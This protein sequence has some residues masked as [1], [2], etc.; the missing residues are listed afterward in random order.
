MAP[1]RLSETPV[2]YVGTNRR[3]LCIEQETGRTV[4]QSEAVGSAENVSLLIHEEKLFSV[5]RTTACCVSRADGKTRWKI[6]LDASVGPYPVLAL[7]PGPRG[8]L[9]L[10]GLGQ[11]FALH[12]ETGAQLW[13]NRLEGLGYHDITLRVPGAIVC[14]PVGHYITTEDSTRFQRTEDEQQ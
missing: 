12:P 10:A 13:H 5:A 9:I 14:Q 11:L 6:K 1:Y 4:W 8:R 3:I 2:F 7:C